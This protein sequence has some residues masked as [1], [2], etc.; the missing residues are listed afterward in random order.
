MEID[1]ERFYSEEY[2]RIRKHIIICVFMFG[3]LIISYILAPLLIE[4]IIPV[5]YH[6]IF[7]NVFPLITMIYLIAMMLGLFVVLFLLYLMRVEL[8][9]SCK[10]LGVR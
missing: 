5:E 6:Y 2:K 3:I 9:K 4:I 10:N 1:I 8:K 7:D